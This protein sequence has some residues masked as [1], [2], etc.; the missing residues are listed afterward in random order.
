MKRSRSSKPFI[1][2]GTIY[3]FRPAS[4]KLM[5]PT[6]RCDLQG[7]TKIQKKCRE[8]LLAEPTVDKQSSCR[9]DSSRRPQSIPFRNKWLNYALASLWYFCFAKC[10]GGWLFGWLDYPRIIDGESKTGGEMAGPCSD[11]KVSTGQ[12]PLTQL[13]PSA[14]QIYSQSTQEAFLSL[15]VLT[16]FYMTNGWLPLKTA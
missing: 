15:V 10:L 13:C 1:P 7:P 12:E 11:N 16:C 4:A 6:S 5:Q 3:Q 9:Q 14:F 2:N 8:A